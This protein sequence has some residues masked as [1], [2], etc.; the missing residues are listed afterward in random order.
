VG[1]VLHV[2]VGQVNLGVFIAE[3]PSQDFQ[4]MAYVG[5]V[6]SYYE[7]ITDNFDRLTDERWTKT[8]QEGPLPPRPDWVN[9]YLADMKGTA[10]TEGRELDGVLYTG[11]HEPG[12]GNANT[13]IN[14][15]FP[16]PFSSSVIIDYSVQPSRQNGFINSKKVDLS[17]FNVR[18]QKVISLVS[19]KQEAGDYR[20][21]W[22]SGE[23]P[24]GVYY[25]RLVTD[26]THHFKKLVRVN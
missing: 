12:M 4:A 3:A 15:V 2:G 8:V 7:S 24:G 6:M 20:V 21:E 19:E 26:N 5:P 22:K 25:I 9:V 1:K 18:G 23:L 11:I 16:N 10:Y 13:N 14:S 17:I